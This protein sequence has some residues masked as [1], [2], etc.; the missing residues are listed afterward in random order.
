M[1]NSDKPKKK[2]IAKKITSN[3]KLQVAARDFRGRFKSRKNNSL[4]ILENA[5]FDISN[6]ESVKAS[7]RV[8][9]GSSTTSH[10]IADSLKLDTSQGKS[11]TISDEVNQR[12]NY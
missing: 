10:P 1:T 7:L 2:E 12:S 5:G 8:N 6:L 9:T 4:K 11:L 3:S